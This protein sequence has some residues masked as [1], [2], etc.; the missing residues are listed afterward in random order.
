MNAIVSAG[1][2]NRYLT[3]AAICSPVTFDYSRKEIGSTGL[4]S[5]FVSRT[6][7]RWAFGRRSLATK[8]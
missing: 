5:R 6:G 8:T 1:I 4:R 3:T 7:K 2:T